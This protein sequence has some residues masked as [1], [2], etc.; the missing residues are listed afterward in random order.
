[1]K[2]V[3][4]HSF[5]GPEVLQLEE[6]PVPEP[7]QGEV[8]VRVHAASVNPV[9]WKTREGKYPAVNAQRLPLV[10]GRDV[11]GHV[12]RCGE[13]V[14]GFSVGEAVYAM[15]DR[16]HG[17]Y[18][19][20]VIVKADDLAVKPGR[21]DFTGAAAVP[22]A[23]MTA[24]QGLFD[25]GQLV[26]GQ[27][28]LIHGGAGGVGH[29]AVQ[30]AKARGAHVTSVVSTE[31]ADFAR[32]LGADEVIDYKRERFEDRVRD[33]DLVFDLIDG[34]TQ[35]RSWQ[36]LKRG[37]TLIS[38]LRRPSEERA[39]TLGARVGNYQAQPNA[40]ELDAIARLIDDDRL[41]PHV[42][43]VFPLEQAREAQQIQQNGHLRGKVVLEV[44]H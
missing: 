2:A 29:L 40:A 18:A 41:R 35:E 9:D 26:S 13:G 30:L 21:L 6:L 22:L 25:H 39:R 12:E 15:L 8:L 34:E 5:G 33:V 19:E 43:R 16:D 31:D 1:M 28:V 42:E 7:A 24:W 23:A 4:I 27:H 44:M 36:V 38:T 37:G 10:L 14:R 11:A 3:R 20:Y 32:Q 17:G